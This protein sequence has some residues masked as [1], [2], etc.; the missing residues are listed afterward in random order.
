MVSLKFEHVATNLGEER[1]RHD[2]F[3]IA[4]VHIVDV[5]VLGRVM[6]Y[7]LFCESVENVLVDM[8]GSSRVLIPSRLVVIV[9]SLYQLS[10]GILEVR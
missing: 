1:E 8:L 5:W 3:I 9:K 7:R 4:V 10:E 6:R 2:F